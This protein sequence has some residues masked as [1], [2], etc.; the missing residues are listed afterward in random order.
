M[1]KILVIQ[2]ASI[3][4]VILSTPVIENL[5]TRF[6]EAAIDLLIKKGM[7]ELFAGHPFIND[8]IIWDKSRKYRDFLRVLKIIRKKRYDLVLNIQRFFLTGLV[9]VFSDARKTI[10]FDKNPLSFLFTERMKHEFRPGVHEAERNLSLIS[11]LTGKDGS[12][13]PKLYPG[14]E[15]EKTVRKFKSGSYV[16]ISPASLWFTKQFPAE[17]WVELIRSLPGETCI[18]LLGSPE[19]RALCEQILKSSDNRKVMNLSGSLRF[20]ES[21]SLMKDALMNYTNDSAPM[22]FASAVN[23]PVAVV[24]CSTVPAFGFGPLSQAQTIIQTTLPLACRPCGIHGRE[25]C[26]EK[27]FQCALS[28]S[29]GQFPLSRKNEIK[30]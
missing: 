30:M 20:L 5:H 7:E 12:R 3:G 28:I 17:K 29:P 10:G 4:D 25:E 26:P 18:F 23:A 27:H 13:M 6:P 16:T 14:P 8:L 22:H 19:D 2:T 15:D 1:Q 11:G 21:V 9:C 24:F